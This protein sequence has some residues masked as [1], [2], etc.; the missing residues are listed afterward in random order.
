MAGFLDKVVVSLNKGVNAVR[1]GLKCFVEKATINSEIQDAEK[2]KNK[3]LLNMGELVFNLMTSENIKLEQCNGMYSE[4]TSY[5]EKITE[6]KQKLQTLD[7]AKVQQPQYSQSETQAV[8]IDGIQCQCGRIN[9]E[10][11][12]FCSKCGHMIQNQEF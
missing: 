4:I 12:K 6:L 8:S 10:G 9:K 3:L 11:A 5:N 7:S 2:E 1:E